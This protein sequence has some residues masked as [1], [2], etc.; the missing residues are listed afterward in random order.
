MQPLFCNYVYI[1][2]VNAGKQWWLV[3]WRIYAS[4]GLNDWLFIHY[5]LIYFEI[6]I[7]NNSGRDNLFQTIFCQLD[8][9]IIKQ[10]QLK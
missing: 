5:S 2:K 4:L 1:H 9:K 6:N 8:F 10:F 7:N 3:Y